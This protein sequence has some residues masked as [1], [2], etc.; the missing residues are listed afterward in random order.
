M[1]QTLRS[2]FSSVLYHST[3]LLGQREMGTRILCYHRVNDETAD[4]L[5][6]PVRQF[7]EQI[8]FLAEEG[9]Q[10][11]GL[12]D[13][14]KG[15][16]APKSIVITFD[17]GFQDNYENAFPVL[18]EFGFSATIF[19]IAK[20]I[21]QPFFLRISEIK[22]MHHAGF[23]FGSHTLTHPH[24]KSLAADKK[25]WEIFGSKRFLEELIGFKCDLFCYPF[26]EYDAQAVRMVEHAGYRAACSNRPGT[27]KEKFNPYLLRRTE[28]GGFDS[29]TD[30]QKKAAGAFDLL[31]QGLH[32]VRKRA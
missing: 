21:G 31:H 9:Y 10:T 16:A 15:A 2:S 11:M 29:L 3:G 12:K 25:W 30:F 27:N 17:D 8:Q 32:W 13:L 26:G 5:S 14:M 1:K 24:L 23:E 22:E 20:K 18:A 19:C 7:R 28:I 6:V 4:Y